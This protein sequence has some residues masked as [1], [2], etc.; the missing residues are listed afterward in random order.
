MYTSI[1]QEVL[2]DIVLH[3]NTQVLSLKSTGIASENTTTIHREGYR[4]VTSRDRPERQFQR[5]TK[6]S[7][8]TS[9]HL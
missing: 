1:I 4:V 8:H 6:K 3:Q 5:G 9:Y 2:S 7:I